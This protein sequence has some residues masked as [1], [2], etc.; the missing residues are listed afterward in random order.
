MRGNP[1][2]VKVTAVIPAPASGNANSV[3]VANPLVDHIGK[4]SAPQVVIPVVR[5]PNTTTREVHVYVVSADVN[6][7][8]LRAVTSETTMTAVTV[9][10]YLG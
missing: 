10:L 8:V 2:L 1:P 5:E 9:D 6:S 3:T 4:K 7:I